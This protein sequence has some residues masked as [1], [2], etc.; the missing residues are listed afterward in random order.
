MIRINLLGV[1]RK[2]RKAP[3]FDV[4]QQ[5][6]LACSLILVAAAFGWHPVRAT[7]PTMTIHRGIT[8]RGSR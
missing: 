1:E 5:L 6:T 3:A 4:S 7:A 8:C 2:T